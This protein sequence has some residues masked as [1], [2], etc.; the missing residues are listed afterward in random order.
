MANQ[1]PPT[2]S[3]YSASLGRQGGNI[4]TLLGVALAIFAVSS[5]GMAINYATMMTIPALGVL[6]GVMLGNA[7]GTAAGNIVAATTYRNRF[8]H[9]FTQARGLAAA[10]AEDPYMTAASLPGEDPALS[11]VAALPPPSEPVA[12]L[13]PPDA[14]G[15]GWSTFVPRNESF[16]QQLVEERLLAEMQ[17]RQL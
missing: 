13:P 10:L 14:A 4:G 2:R 16:T 11:A 9:E 8:S 3:E 6:A 15:K 1:Y 12:L 7:L 17:Q 5:S